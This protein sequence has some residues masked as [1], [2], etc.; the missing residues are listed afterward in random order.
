M[1]PKERQKIQG[2]T[3]AYG[4]DTITLNQGDQHILLTGELASWMIRSLLKNIPIE[5]KN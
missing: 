3:I 1:T 5:I 2:L 4:T